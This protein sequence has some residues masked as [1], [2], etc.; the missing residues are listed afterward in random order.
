MYFISRNKRWGAIGIFLFIA[1]VCYIGPARIAGAAQKAYNRLMLLTL[2]LDK[3]ERFYVDEKNPDA[4]I[5][6]AIQGMLSALDPHT[7]FLSSEEY[8]A[9]KSRYQGYQG[10]GVKYS[11]LR[12]RLLVISVVPNSPAADQGIHPGD[13]ITRIA[14]K[15]IEYLEPEDITRLLQESTVRLEI[16]HKGEARARDLVLPKRISPPITVPCAFMVSDTIGFIKIDHFSDGTPAELDQAFSQ[17]QSSVPVGL[18][19]DLRDNGGGSFNAAIKVVDRFLPAGKLIAY[20]RGRGPGANMQYFSTASTKLPYIPLIVLVNGSSASDAE[21]VAGAVQDWDRGL[22]IGQSTYGKALVQTEYAFQDGSALLLTTARFFTPLGRSLQK[23][24]GGDTAS[25]V[26]RTPQ[27]RTVRGGGS[28]IPD[29]TLSPQQEL[30]S[31][32]LQNLVSS[33]ENYFADFADHYYSKNPQWEKDRVYFVRSFKVSDDMLRDFLILLRRSGAR[34][35]LQ[36]FSENKEHLQLLIKREIA[37]LYWGEEARNMVNILA[38]QEVI[39]SC[40]YLP[41]AK[42]LLFP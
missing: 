36:D 15:K 7:I 16:K 34:F 11:V 26:F 14:G 40:K 9:Y 37:A 35:T 8:S 21:I 6:S 23:N 29:I 19:I 32:A 3:I 18:I 24:D 5:E 4:L 41:Q 20:T 12:D 27:G 42:E 31:V 13:R 10:I 1:L 17:L 28:I 30:L 2:V 33:N 38:D 25:P 39:E 22:I